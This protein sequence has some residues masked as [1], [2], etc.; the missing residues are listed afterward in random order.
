M[1]FKR[2]PGIPRSCQSPGKKQ[3]ILGKT[4]LTST[5][6][7]GTSI[8]SRLISPKTACSNPVASSYN[9]ASSRFITQVSASRGTI[10]ITWE[11]VLENERS[12]PP[13]TG[14]SS[15]GIDWNG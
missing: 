6:P 3:R 9:P 13:A 15:T 14:I 11:A 7:S 10:N 4:L 8:C 5:A 12:G 2:V 1:L